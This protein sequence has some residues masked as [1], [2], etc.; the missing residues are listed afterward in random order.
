MTDLGDHSVIK[1]IYDIN[2]TLVNSNPFVVLGPALDDGDYTPAEGVGIVINGVNAGAVNFPA[3][4][5]HAYTFS[6]DIDNVFQVMGGEG[7]DGSLWYRIWDN[8]GEAWYD[9]KEI[10]TRAVK[11]DAFDLGITDYVISKISH[12]SGKIVTVAGYLKFGE[13]IPLGVGGEAAVTGVFIGSQTDFYSGRITDGQQINNVF[14]FQV[15]SNQWNIVSNGTGGG[16]S[17]SFTMHV[18]S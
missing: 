12:G 6:L 14:E 16:R 3:A 15:I 8:I 7:L 1:A 17:F 5:G 9:W 11:I 10:P 2:T 13:S 4:P 18:V